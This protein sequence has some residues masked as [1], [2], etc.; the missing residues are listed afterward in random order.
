MATI[1]VILA[2]DRHRSLSGREVELIVHD[3]QQQQRCAHDTCDPR[4]RDCR[5]WHR[6]PLTTVAPRHS[7]QAA[8]SIRTRRDFWAG[9]PTGRT[10]RVTNTA[11][12]TLPALVI[13]RRRG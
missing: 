1:V 4:V 3:L 8:S 13:R 12:S 9:A 11:A 10:P 7:R 5:C 6:P 2:Q